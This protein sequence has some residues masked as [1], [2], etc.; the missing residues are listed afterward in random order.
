M[1]SAIVAIC[2]FVGIAD[3]I[4]QAIKGTGH[5]LGHV[6]KWAA[7]IFLVL[8]AVGILGTIFGPNGRM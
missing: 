7:I 1:V 6:V 8:L 2:F 3:L 5:L 4:G